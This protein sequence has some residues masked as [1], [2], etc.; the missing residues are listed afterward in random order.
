MKFAHLQEGVRIFKR[1]NRVKRHGLHEYEGNAEE[2]CRKIVEECW[3]GN[4]LQT[5][6][7]HGH[8]CCFYMR[9]FGWAIDSLLK[10][11]YEER[12][13]K[14]LEYVLGVYSKDKLTTTITPK[15]KCIDVFKYSPDSIAYLVRCLK[16]GGKKDTIER[17]EDFILKEVKKCYELCFDEVNSLIRRDKEFGSMKDSTHRNCSTYDNTMLAMLSMDLNSLDLDNPFQG[18]DIKRAMKENLWNGEYFYDDIHKRDFVTGENNTYPYWTGVFT[19][20]N[21]VKSSIRSIQT[22]GLDDPFPLKYSSKK[23]SKEMFWRKWIVSDYQT[24]SIKTHMGAIYIHVVKKVNPELAR[25]YT[26]IY[27]EKIE[28]HKTYLENFNSQ[29]EPLDTTFYYSD[30]GNLWA[31]NYVTL[32]ADV[33]KKKE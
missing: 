7:N 33:Y 30:E 27:T 6:T 12:V 17:Y 31:A 4:Y 29:G 20:E 1:R 13:Q 32:I 3:N 18:Y 23:V 15:N 24:H 9:D 2:I 16:L 19:D 14:T 11:G 25:R 21:M 8:Y 28:K 26:E 5:S 10:M 22:A